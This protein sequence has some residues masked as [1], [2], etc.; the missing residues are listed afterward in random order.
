MGCVQLDV[1]QYTAFA[2]PKDKGRQYEFVA[3]SNAVSNITSV[4]L[5]NMFHTVL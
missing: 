2:V 3:I 1:G 4:Q 5:L